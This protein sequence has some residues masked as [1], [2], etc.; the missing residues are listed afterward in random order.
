[1]V[2]GIYFDGVASVLTVS[3]FVRTD[4]HQDQHAA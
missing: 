2:E 1:M 4:I 3:V